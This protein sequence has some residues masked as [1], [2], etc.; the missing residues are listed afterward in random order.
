MRVIH[1]VSNPV[2]GGG[3]RYVLDLSA[4]LMA[5]GH[6]VT[7]VTRPVDAVRSPF[8]MASVP[9]VT[10]PLSEKFGGALDFTSPRRLARMFTEAT[11]QGEPVVVHVHNFSMA[12]LA[13]AA[14]KRSARP[15]LVKI[16]CTRHLVRP[17]KSS[18]RYVRLYN[19][20][21]A[22]VF[23]SRIARETFLSTNPNIPSERLSVVHNSVRLPQELESFH[24]HNSSSP[25]RLLFA[26]RLAPEKGIEVLFEALSL[27]KELPWTLTLCGTG[28][29]AYLARLRDIVSTLGL[30]SRIKFAGHVADMFPVIDSH[31]IGILPTIVAEACGLSV[32]ECMSRGVP[33]VATSN[34]GQAEYLHN[35]VDSLLVPPGDA[36][37]LSDAIRMLI[38]D[39]VLLFKLSTNALSTFRSSLSYPH[40]YQHILDIYTNLI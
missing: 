1:L 17:A 7:V 19:E 16:I 36:A 33:V 35:S 27:I 26:G 23:V 25:L 28:M 2:W 34:G 38:G 15:D 29:P 6:D 18:S 24:T 3:E 14:R 39:R 22:I 4:T 8:V 13:V 37:A 12:R 10:M 31:D 11:A 32:M 30:D 5:D 9:T 40:F 20:L 21:D